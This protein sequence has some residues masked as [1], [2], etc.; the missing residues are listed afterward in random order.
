M[1]GP[2]FG[3]EWP[4]GYDKLK[5]HTPKHKDKT[6]RPKGRGADLH[7]PAEKWFRELYPHGAWGPL[8]GYRYA[9]GRYISSDFCG[10]G[11]FLGVIDGQTMIVQVTTLADVGA[12]LR[13]YSNPKNT[14]KERPICDYIHEFLSAGTWFVILGFYKE[15]GSRYWSVKETNVTKELLA[16][17]AARIRA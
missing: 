17:Y 2:D 3:S 1:I 10:F 5:E 12:H 4:E 9:G 11:D 8:Y 7:K 16:E 13:K 14:W 15:E 6:S